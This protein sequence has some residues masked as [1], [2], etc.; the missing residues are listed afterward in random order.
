MFSKEYWKSSAD[1]L[2]QTK[3]LALMAVF[4]AMKCVVS[5]LYVPVGENLRITFGFILRAVEGVIFGPVACA[6]SGIITDLVSF[7]EHPTGAFFIGY[8]ISAMLGSLTYAL[9][10]YR[11]KTDLLHI[12]L[13]KLTVNYV[14]NVLVGSIWSAILYSK[15]YIY[16]VTKSLVKNTLML[17][18]EI[19]ALVLVFRFITP[20]LK[21]RR[22]I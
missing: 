8:T 21:K 19:I 4:I 10:F 22:L 1:K 3:Y 20:L 13:C 14:V 17:P 5:Y 2:R 6:L 15:G 12:I 7:M 16:Y 11:Q 9:F 18:F